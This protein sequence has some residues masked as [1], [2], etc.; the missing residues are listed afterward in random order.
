[1]ELDGSGASEPACRT[2]ALF[3][4]NTTVEPHL[5]GYDRSHDEKQKRSVCAVSCRQADMMMWTASLDLPYL[6]NV[7]NSAFFASQWNDIW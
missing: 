2:N 4:A 6:F 5:L 7:E 1:M 3:V